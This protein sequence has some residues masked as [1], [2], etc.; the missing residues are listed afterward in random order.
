MKKVANLCCRGAVLARAEKMGALRRPGKAEGMNAVAGAISSATKT[1]RLSIV[2]GCV[3]GTRLLAGIAVGDQPL[4]FAQT[5]LS[6]KNSGTVEECAKCNLKCFRC[7][8]N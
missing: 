6:Y 4:G 5:L 7:S 1:S 2:G 8:K 3:G